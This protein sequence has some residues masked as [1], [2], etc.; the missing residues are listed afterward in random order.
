ML[1][2]Q[3]SVNVSNLRFSLRL[4]LRP[5]SVNSDYLRAG[6]LVKSFFAQPL[7]READLSR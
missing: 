2:S 7:A 6:V 3:M 4:P 1:S 5:E